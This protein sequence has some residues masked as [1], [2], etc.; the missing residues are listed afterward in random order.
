VRHVIRADLDEVIHPGSS[1]S[2]RP[3]ARALGIEVVATR[4]SDA[5]VCALCRRLI[6]A[7]H[8]PNEPMEVYRGT[9]LA[10]RV[11]SIGEAAKLTVEE[12]KTGPRFRVAR[13]FW[14]SS[15][16]GQLDQD[17]SNDDE[18]SQPLAAE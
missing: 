12:T 8:D 15:E 10:L 3:R 7:G 4:K 6:E 14:Q 18:P 11:R 2:R 17:A 16:D 9:T 1:Y 5:V 13:P